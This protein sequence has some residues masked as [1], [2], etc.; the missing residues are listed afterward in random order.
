MLSFVSSPNPEWGETWAP[1]AVRSK[2]PSVAPSSVVPKSPPRAKSVAK[3]KYRSKVIGSSA[4]ALMTLLP[5]QPSADT[6]VKPPSSQKRRSPKS[7]PKS[8]SK[9][10]RNSFLAKPPTLPTDSKKSTGVETFP[11]GPGESAQ[12]SAASFIPSQ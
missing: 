2:E 8:H 11:S 9:I 6:Q 4:L 10:L 7:P 1:S 3:K 12:P 5:K